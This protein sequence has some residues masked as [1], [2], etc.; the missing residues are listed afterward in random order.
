M[1]YEN[2]LETVLSE[3][4][5]SELDGLIN[6][7][8]LPHN[9][10]AGK[11]IA[12]IT[13]R[14]ER[15]TMKKNIS[16]RSVAAIAAIAAALAMTVTAGAAVYKTFFHKESAEKFGIVNESNSE[17][18]IGTTSSENAHLRMTADTVLSDGY[19]AMVIFTLEAL[20]EQGKEY[21][22]DKNDQY[23][24]F[25]TMLY[26]TSKELVYNKNTLRTD[27][28]TKIFPLAYSKENS[29]GSI[30]YSYTQFFGNDNPGTIY[31]VPEEWRLCEH[32]ELKDEASV[33]DGISLE[34]DVKRNVEI[35]EL[36][37]DKNKLVLTK[38]G[39]MVIEGDNDEFEIPEAYSK[40][41]L[42]YKDGRKEQMDKTKGYS[43]HSDGKGYTYVFKVIDDVN[44]ISAVIY[45]D[46][47]YK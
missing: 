41:E 22:S 11:I 44:D 31:V 10:K 12:E 43:T 20:D 23:G 27:P 21:I 39:A 35:R 17:L 15:I 8:E 7:I 38:L 26:S 16:K 1:N 47:E 18:V 29:D 30:A 13:A 45:N 24:V 36:S 6:D 4:D 33:F 2:E 40:F 37:N 34:L 42:V 28:D 9:R 25:P 5:V 46:K 14:K 19:K 32:E 3:L